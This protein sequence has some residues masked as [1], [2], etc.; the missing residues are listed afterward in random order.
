M[1]WQSL[2]NND[3]QERVVM[4]DPPAGWCCDVQHGDRDQWSWQ[5]CH[6]DGDEFYRRGYPTERA[7][8]LSCEAALLRLGILQLPCQ[9]SESGRA[10]QM[11]DNHTG[12]V[13]MQN[14]KLWEATVYCGAVHDTLFR[15]SLV[16]AQAAAERH[17]RDDLTAW[18][19][20]QAAKEG[21]Q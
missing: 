15:P 8:Q 21:A 4:L 7:A 9:W 2:A 10:Q 17:L 12:A 11:G 19:D 13:V 3:D 18:L 14:G 20:E 16:A 1:Q 5:A 6:T